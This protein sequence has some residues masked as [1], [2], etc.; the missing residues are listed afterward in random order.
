[1]DFMTGKRKRCSAAF[2]AKVARRVLECAGSRRLLVV[3]RE[4]SLRA[5]SP[6]R[7][8]PRADSRL[9]RRWRLAPLSA[10]ELAAA[11]ESGD[12]ASLSQLVSI[13]SDCPQPVLV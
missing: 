13:Y 1:M 8:T 9:L 11:L 10:A 2:K 4:K 3:P 5:H 12:A 6:S 7:A